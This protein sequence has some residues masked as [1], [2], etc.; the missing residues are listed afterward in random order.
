MGDGIYGVTSKGFVI[1]RL[2]AI[3]DSIYEYLAQPE[4]TGWGIDPRI[5][6]GV[7]NQNLQ[8]VLNVLITSFGN[9]ISALWE[10]GQDSYFAMYPNTAFGISLENACLFGGV[11][12]SQNAFSIYPLTCTGDDNTSIPYGSLVQSTIAPIQQLQA[13]YTQTISSENFVSVKIGV[14]SVSVG[15]IYNVTINGIAYTYTAVEGDTADII[16]NAIVTAITN[17]TSS[18]TLSITDSVLTITDPMFNSNNVVVSSYLEILQVKTIVFFATLNYGNIQI[19]TGTITHIISSRPGWYGVKNELSYTAG[20]LQENDISLRHSYENE[21]GNNS[22]GTVSGIV[23]ALRQLP[24][25]IDVNG[26]DNKTSSVDALGLLPH[27]VWFIVEG[28]DQSSIAQ[29]IFNKGTGGI[30][31]NGDVSVSIMDDYG[32]T[33]LI[34][35]DRPIVKYAWLKIELTPMQGRSLPSDYIL[36]TKNALL[37]WVSTNV[38][39]G[40]SVYI[41]QSYANIYSAI[42]NLA[43]VNI[44]AALTDV[45]VAPVTYTLTN[46]PISQNEKAIFSVLDGPDQIEVILL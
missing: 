4:P 32:N 33:Q 29:V 46:I 41:Q 27:S 37:Q 1:K 9:E 26:F 8:S 21:M 11:E 3:L 17:A 13:T 42:P 2:D 34:Q 40:Q 39:M 12:R 36:L 44:T 35:F 10:V 28:G 20:Q 24:G 23:A 15:T 25:V 45:L 30:N 22:N 5:I 43:L 19:P 16:L 7:D 18:F 6:D 38:K 14:I 31:T